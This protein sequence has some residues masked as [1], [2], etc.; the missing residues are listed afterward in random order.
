[1]V[2]HTASPVM[3]VVVVAAAYEVVAEVVNQFL[4]EDVLPSL[5]SKVEQFSWG[6][7]ARRLKPA[8]ALPVTFVAVGFVLSRVNGARSRQ[9]SKR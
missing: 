3:G 5:L 7:V 4:D 8:W 2:R 1:M 6:R 9:P